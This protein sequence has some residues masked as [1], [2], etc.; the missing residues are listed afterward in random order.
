MKFR[1]SLALFSL[2]LLSLAFSSCKKED[3]TGT[4]TVRMKDDPID[5]DSVNVEVLQVQVHVSNNGQGGSGW[6]E[7]PTNSGIYNLLDLQNNIT[8]VLVN[9]NTLPVGE[10]QQM[11]LILGS[12]NSVVVDG[13]NYPLETS[14]QTNTGLKFNVNASINPGD[15]VEVLID[16]DAAQSI[17]IQ[18]NGTSFQLKPVIKVA[19]VFYF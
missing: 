7:L 6:V 4:L 11:R 9:N 13:I 17:V 15:G 10:I 2:F 16:F 5:F 12:N 19:G 14:S 8:A 1:L 3:A 18:G